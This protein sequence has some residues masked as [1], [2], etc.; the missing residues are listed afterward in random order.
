MCS[1]TARGFAF[2]VIAASVACCNAARFAP[3]IETKGED[4]FLNVGEGADV[5][6]TYPGADPISF[7]A[8][9]KS[10]NSLTLK[11]E[12][13][14]GLPADITSARAD[15]KALQDL[16]ATLATK[17]E[18]SSTVASASSDSKKEID[19]NKQGVAEAKA[20][21]NSAIA[22]ANGNKNDVSKNAA[23]LKCQASFP[24]ALPLNARVIPSLCKSLADGETCSV[25]CQSDFIS[26]KS[27]NLALGKP[28]LLDVG[29]SSFTRR[30][31]LSAITDGIENTD[32]SRYLA[33]CDDYDSYSGS[34]ERPQ[35]VRGNRPC[36]VSVDLGQAQNVDEIYFSIG[37]GDADAPYYVCKHEI[38]VS[39][40]NVQWTTVAT[41]DHPMNFVS[42][43]SFDP[44]Q[45]RW[46]R[47]T[48]DMSCKSSITARYSGML[49]LREIAVY[50][51]SISQLKCTDGAWAARTKDDVLECVERQSL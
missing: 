25:Q 36:K 46:V 22:T 13:M 41:V 11:M 40:N 44:V 14:E 5:V 48:F 20:S 28:A 2:V 17:D 30:Q 29:V 49:R 21:A 4:I 15:I 12:A 9:Q 45:A 27:K 31:N 43:D 7:A 35:N 8:L 51:H 10:V 19:L 33:W 34:L 37:L 3:N 18:L 47:I 1:T 26:A 39:T 23:D 24:A 50:D 6:V 32:E 38:E 42:A 16:V